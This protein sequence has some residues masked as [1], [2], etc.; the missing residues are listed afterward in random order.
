MTNQKVKTRSYGPVGESSELERVRSSADDSNDLRFQLSETVGDHENGIGIIEVRS[1]NSA[2][3][4]QKKNR[5]DED[6]ARTHQ[7]VHRFSH[8]L[9]LLSDKKEMRFR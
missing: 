1:G 9:T 5:E 4:H 8:S 2:A 3:E 6:R 7:F